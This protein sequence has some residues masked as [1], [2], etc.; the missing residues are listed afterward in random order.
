MEYRSYKKRRNY[1]IVLVNPLPPECNDFTNGTKYLMNGDKKVNAF[2]LSA[3]KSECTIDLEIN[4][5]TCGKGGVGHLKQL[6]YVK[7]PNIQIKEFK[8]KRMDGDIKQSV[9]IK[10]VR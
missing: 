3:D 1:V 5:R 4:C 10:N 7:F 2:N 9:K 6:L 8:R